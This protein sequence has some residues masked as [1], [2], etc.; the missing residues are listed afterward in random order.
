GATVR[1][2]GNFTA[3][4]QAEFYVRYGNVPNRGLFDQVFPY[5]QSLRQDLLLTGTAGPY[6]ILLLGREGG[7]A[8]LAFSLRADVLSLEV[9]SASPAAGSNRGRV[10]TTVT[11]SGFSPATHVS[12]TD[13]NGVRHD[14]AAVTFRDSNTLIVTFDLTGLPA[15]LADIRVE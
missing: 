15:G 7:G 13:S 10:T 1:L 6:Y 4:A 11:G 2:T 12:L 9:R 8:G 14:A 5:P 3:S